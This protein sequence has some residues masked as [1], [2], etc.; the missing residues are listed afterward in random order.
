MGVWQL[1]LLDTAV[2]LA[3]LCLEGKTDHGVTGV[4]SGNQLWGLLPPYHLFSAGP[5]LVSLCLLSA[6]LSTYTAF[7]TS[8]LTIFK[9]L[10]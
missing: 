3:V 2:D 1:V 10:K 6:S 9:L 8:I 4:T 7:K 5:F